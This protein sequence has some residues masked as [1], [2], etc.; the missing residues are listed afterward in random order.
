[1]PVFLQSRHVHNVVFI[2]FFQ[3]GRQDDVMPTA[4]PSSLGNGLDQGSSADRRRAAGRALG[5]PATRQGPSN[6]PQSAGRR[7]L[8]LLGPRNPPGPACHFVRRKSPASP[9]RH[10]G[11]FR[12][13]IFRA[14]R[15]RRGRGGS[16][17]P[18]RPLLPSHPLGTVPVRW[19]CSS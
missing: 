15:L 6:R 13:G 7:G 8:R 17:R 4:A 18:T 5:L 19:C 11:R 12:L 1:L 14:L 16:R 10:R 2:A 3:L 9:L